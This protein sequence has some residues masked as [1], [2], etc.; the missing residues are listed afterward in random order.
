MRGPINISSA[1]IFCEMKRK[2]ALSM[3]FR[4]SF[5]VSIRTQFSSVG[6]CSRGERRFLLLSSAE[7]ARCRLTC[8]NVF[9]GDACV[10]CECS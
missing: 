6:F 5:R 3:L 4:F 2:M 1:G 10:E 9:V 8:F 7:R